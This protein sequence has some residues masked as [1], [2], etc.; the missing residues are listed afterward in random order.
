MTLGKDTGEEWVKEA[1]GYSESGEQLAEDADRCMG[2][3]GRNFPLLD[4][5]GKPCLHH[6]LKLRANCSC[7]C[8]RTVWSVEAGQGR[9]GTPL[10]DPPGPED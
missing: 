3:P 7:V 8:R 6:K 2:D 1:M 5:S 4:T 10:S 9:S